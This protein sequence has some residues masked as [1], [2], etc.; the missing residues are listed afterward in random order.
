[1]TIWERRCTRASLCGVLASLALLSMTAAAAQP[2]A[3]QPPTPQ[4]PPAPGEQV[5]VFRSGIDLVTVDV[6]I[7]DG[8]GN[9]IRNLAQEDFT[10]EVDGEP[11]KLVSVEYVSYVVPERVEKR[12]QPPA[13]HYSSN[14]D[15]PLGRL[16]LLV[17]DQGNIR[18]GEG[19]A[20]MAT[21]RKFLDRLTPSDRVGLAVIPELGPRIGFTSNHAIIR[22]T[23]SRV[24]GRADV[25]ETRFN[26]G[27]SE[28]LAVERDDSLAFRELASR[29]CANQGPECTGFLEIE[30]RAMAVH[31]LTQTRISVGT[32]RSLIDDMRGVPGPKTIVLLSEGLVADYSLS[33]FERLGLSALSARV[34]IYVLRLDTPRVEASQARL[35]PTASQDERVREEGL[36]HLA[37]TARG[38]FFRV[39]STGEYAFQRISRELSGHYLLAFEPQKADRN[40]KLH[41]I[42]VRTKRQGVTI[43]A[44]S[45]FAAG[46]TAEAASERAG[47]LPKSGTEVEQLSGLLD[48]PLTATELPLRVTNFAF[49]DPESS[50]LKIVIAAE[51]DTSSSTGLIIG[52]TMMDEGGRVAARGAE[53]TTSPRY[54]ATTTIRPG[55][56]TLRVAAIDSSGRRGSV[57]R[58]VSATLISSRGYRMGDLMLAEPGELRGMPSR[59]TI[60]GASADRL[61]AYVELYAAGVQQLQDASVDVEV[62]EAEDT[63]ALVSQKA[64]LSRP[65]KGRRIAQTLLPIRLLPPGDYVAR[66][67]VKSGDRSIARLARPF[68]VYRTLVAADP[69]AA[70]AALREDPAGAGEHA[71][72]LPAVAPLR[73]DVPRYSRE[74]V[75]RPSILDFFL[76]ETTKFQEGPASAPIAAAIGRARTKRFDELLKELPSD[77]TKI[78][79]ENERVTAAFLRGLAFYAKGDLEPASKT[80]NVI[81]SIDPEFAPALVYLGACYAAAGRDGE[82]VGAWQTSLSLD[83]EA[84]AT[85][86]LLADALFRMNDGA[87]ALAILSEAIEKWPDDD[88]FLRPLATAYAMS[89]RYSEAFGALE[90]HLA[91]HPSDPDGL[92]LALRMIY[93]AHLSGRPLVGA[94]E[95]KDRLTKYAKTYAQAG[96]PQQLI[97]AQWVRYLAA[98]H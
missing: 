54:A 73:P 56:Y 90:R 57:E 6:G 1:M 61:L 82:A 38:A 31:Y 9:P 4:P 76:A 87:Q 34:N 59:P 65:D 93:E 45:E 98:K 64:D 81:L 7:F 19:R 70:G 3:K 39:T 88:E 68:H 69:A 77:L 66:A 12:Q 33:E 5:P 80:F 13:V 27:L 2:P 83:A 49:Q 72:G 63:P 26:I 44:R 24:V 35:S 41:K 71:T 55:N 52:F 25:F 42:R 58:R 96:G 67:V 36:E 51:A 37:G 20:V 50:R 78:A 75:L 74:D 86:H 60:V 79:N 47:S 62:G 40:G 15:A 92:F 95:D 53:R 11:R 32:L 28:A 30:A 23:L 18:Q 46:P 97:V 22:E 14:E 48:A 94:Q 43:R 89:S 16:I 21:A 84:P 91:K 85:F 10:L 29:E 8:E 17:V